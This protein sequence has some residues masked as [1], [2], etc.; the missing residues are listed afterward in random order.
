MTA[1]ADKLTP[2][3]DALAACANALAPHREA[4]FAS[5]RRQGFPHRRVEGW[6]W[7]DF[8]AALRNAPGASAPIHEE[9]AAIFRRSA[10]AAGE[11]RIVNGRIDF[12][13]EPLP[14]G[15]RYGIVVTVTHDA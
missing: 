15:V 6:R 8:K 2:L 7:S 3:E 10:S 1:N 12:K 11:I 9:R 5:Y 14:D 4:A 13:A